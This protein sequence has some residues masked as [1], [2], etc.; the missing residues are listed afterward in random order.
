MPVCLRI[1]DRL[2]I[3]QEKIVDDLAFARGLLVAGSWFSGANSGVW[4][5]L[6]NGYPLAT[7]DAFGFRCALTGFSI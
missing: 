4:T 6:W 5:S 3:S 7:G 2:S 1:H